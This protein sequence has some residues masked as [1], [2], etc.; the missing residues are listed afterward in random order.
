MTARPYGFRVV[1]H[2]AGRRRLVD[3]RAALAAYAGC[4]PKAQLE[5]EAYLSHFV[6]GARLRRLPGARENREGL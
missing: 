6:F 2:R 1:G 5:R 4:D 3:W